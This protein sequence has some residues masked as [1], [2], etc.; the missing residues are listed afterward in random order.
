M[1]HIAEYGRDPRFSNSEHRY[2]EFR[3]VQSRFIAL[4]FGKQSGELRRS[5]AQWHP[6]SAR[7][8]P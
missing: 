4:D 7:G 1:W 8:F 2:V 3:S 5:C 6:L